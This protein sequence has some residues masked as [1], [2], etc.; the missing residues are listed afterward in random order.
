LGAIVDEGGGGCPP[1]QDQRQ[2]LDAWKNYTNSHGGI[3]GHPV[4]VIVMNSACNPAQAAVAAQQLIADHVLAIVDGTSL[5]TVL[6]KA[7]DAAHIPVLCGTMSGQSFVCQSD[8]NFF[9]A[10]A[11]VLANTYGNMLAIRKA[12]AKTVGIVYCTENVAC[13]QALPLFK[14]YATAV[15][16]RDVGAVAASTAATSYTAQCLVMQQE[17]AAA[18][19]GA[20]PPSGKLADDCARQGYHPIYV[21]SEGTWQTAYLHDPNLDNAAGDTSFVPWF[22]ND[23]P[24]TAL[25]HQV[26]GSILDATNYPYN[27]L[28]SYGAALLFQRVL[29]NAPAA[30]STQDVY[31][32]LYSLHGDTLGGFSPPLTF[33]RGK[34]AAINCFFFES[35][36]GGKF[37]A[38]NGST[39]SCQPQ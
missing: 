19:F 13:K 7:A 22:V 9:S 6:P 30:V 14:S 21:E 8:A 37:V 20:G 16:M 34:P 39:P 36:K 27:V 15:G 2:T 12:G 31:S 28:G 24:T 23:S 3:S 4:D 11:T 18:V 5:D 10:G 17:H 32:G 33:E 25:F 26:A 29:A 38:P 35:I 1:T